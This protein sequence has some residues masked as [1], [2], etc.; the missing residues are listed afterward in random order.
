MEAL[1]EGDVQRVSDTADHPKDLQQIKM[2]PGRELPPA[3]ALFL[4]SLLVLQILKAW[5]QGVLD[6]C[7]A[8]RNVRGRIPDGG[9][10]L[11]DEK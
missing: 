6:H 3:R 7:A 11:A 9:A 2:V 8:V 4:L 10:H 1:P 5:T